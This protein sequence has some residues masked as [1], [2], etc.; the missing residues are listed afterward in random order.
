MQTSPQWTRRR[1][2][3]GV[4]LIEILVVLAILVV[5]ILAIIRLFPSGFFSIESVGNTALADT[6]GSG[7]L[8]AQAQDAAGLPSAI[9]ANGLV[10]SQY[11]SSDFSSF[12]PDFS[13]VLDM[14]RKVQDE[15][16]TVPAH[17]L[18]T[19]SYGPIVMPVALNQQQVVNSLTINSAWWAG[20]LG[21]STTA[22]GVT[23]D[24]P[25]ASLSPRQERF[26]VDLANKKIAVPMA[27]Y[28]PIAKSSTD[29]EGYDQKMIVVIT[30]ANGENFTEYLSVPKGVKRDSSN[31]NAPF[32]AL[33]VQY[34]ADT[35]TNYQGGWFDPTATYGDTTTII[36]VPPAT[37]QV[38]VQDAQGKPL[39]W[40]KVSIY[41]PFQPQ[42]TTAFTADPYQY[43]LASPSIADAGGT[44]VANLGTVSF[45]P[46][47][48]GSMG[49]KPIKARIS[50]QVY[51]WRVLHEDRDLTAA[52][53]AG[54]TVT[55]LTLK[56]LKKVGDPQSDN[57]IYPGL[58]AEENPATPQSV[59]F[60][61]LDTGQP[62]A[63][64]I[65]DE[66]ANGTAA[67]NIN[68]SYA[69][70][71][72]TFPSTVTAR[73]VRIFYAGDQDWT[74]AVQKAPDTY[75]RDPDVT[76][77][78]PAMPIVAGETAYAIYAGE[79]AF[80]YD[81]AIGNGDPGLFFPR[82]DAGKTV[83]VDGLVAYD[84]NGKA[85]SCPSVTVAIGDVPVPLPAGGVGYVE[86]D[87]KD[88]I[89]SALGGATLGTNAGSP[90][91]SP[92]TITA[93]RGLSARA[94]VAW[95]ERGRW[96][97]HVVDTILARPQ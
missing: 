66:D 31:P 62:I 45:N 2:R 30:A 60:L 77:T 81:P 28:V 25:Q 89:K 95:T 55:R 70:G 19:V 5:G 24:V 10:E 53:G 64:T 26:L 47:A 59:M 13:K 12:V 32:D 75:V 92:V 22:A 51:S 3:R 91:T 8:G 38:P 42:A 68:V 74:V 37:A 14:S 6:I 27:P 35:G 52:N 71:R 9:L 48:A 15:T 7:E 20:S 79:T 80:G 84:T 93:V 83:E 40:V 1:N 50:Y 97:T 29:A 4:S 61:D 58:I 34:I 87:L 76:K 85:Y 72:V 54:G 44:P 11:S 88:T 65:N 18:Y 69:T 16:I 86:V 73:R 46:L 43:T 21:D 56:N 78:G 63:T 33:N 23:Q 41:R 49:I 36:P 57:T 82:C 39:D 17:N 94:V 67:G 96:K 90:G